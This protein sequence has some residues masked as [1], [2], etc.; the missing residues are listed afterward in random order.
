MSNFNRI[1]NCNDEYELADILTTFMCKNLHELL[2]EDGTF[3]SLYLL[4]WLQSDKNMEG[5]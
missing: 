5:N 3:N 1:K 4:R 2:N